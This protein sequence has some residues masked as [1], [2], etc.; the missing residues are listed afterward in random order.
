MKQTAF[1]LYIFLILL[2]SFSFLPKT[3]S[4]ETLDG[5]PADTIKLADLSLNGIPFVTT[6]KILLRYLGKPDSIVTPHYECGGFSDNWEG[7]TFY[8]YYYSQ[9]NYIGKRDSFQ[10]KSIEFNNTTA[11]NLRY[12]KHTLNHATKIS[13]LEFVFP[14]S[15]TSRTL[16]AGL[17]VLIQIA[18]EEYPSDYI[19][20]YFRKGLLVKL[21][22]WT[23]C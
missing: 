10:V 16:L 8:Q 3:S 21:E 22:Y 17:D 5:Y 18:P 23:P 15:Y 11:L 1:I 7:G 2:S 6:K 4:P 13:S 20:L 12:K 14:N 19:Y 9:F